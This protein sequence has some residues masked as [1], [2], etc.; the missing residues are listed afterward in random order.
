MIV[1]KMIAVVF[2][3]AAC[4]MCASVAFASNYNDSEAI[5]LNNDKD[6]I[7]YSD[8]NE[9]TYSET[10]AYDI[11]SPYVAAA[12]N[13]G[14]KNVNISK[15]ITLKKGESK[16]YSFDV[17]GG[18]FSPDHNTVSVVITKTA[19]SSYR[20]ISEDVTTGTELANVTYYGNA[21]RTLSNLD[22]SHTYEVTLINLGTSDLTLG[23]SITSYID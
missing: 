21:N 18:L 4:L 5:D 9:G 11:E 6:F 22:S 12:D 3:V 14:A 20:Y 13:G 1:K 17:S 15:T 7:E 10:E 16:T 8:E 23:V 19:G 2:A